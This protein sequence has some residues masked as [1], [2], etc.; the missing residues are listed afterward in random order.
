ML[1][2]D[3]LPGWFT[4][5]ALAWISVI[6]V[7]RWLL[8]RDSIMDKRFNEIALF[9]A[10]SSLLREPRVTEWISPVVPGGA[11]VINDVW[12]FTFILMCTSIMG[13]FFFQ[14]PNLDYRRA[15]N[16]YRLWIVVACVVGVL[17]VILS[18]SARAKGL[19]LQDD[20]SWRYGTYFALYGSVQ[21]VT[22]FYGVRFLRAVRGAIDSLRDRVVVA[23]VFLIAIGG[24]FNMSLLV[25]GTI[26][27]SAGVDDGFTRET[28]IRASGE[29]L[30]PF[31]A[32]GFV[33]LVPSAAR[34]VGDVL[35]IDSAS[36]EARRLRPVWRELLAATP[37]VRM[38]LTLLDRLGSRSPER[39]H[40]MRR[41]ISH[42]ASNVSR[43]I[44]GLDNV[45]DD[46]IDKVVPVES[47]EPLRVVT[48]LMVAARWLTARGGLA[49]AGEPTNPRGAAIDVDTLV[50]LWPQAREVLDQ[51]GY[52]LV[53]DSPR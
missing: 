39:L 19:L 24:A 14:N 12:H 42:A 29:L 22:C 20:P 9:A 48:E 40:R 45:V 28:E 49:V 18:S 33:A 36:S 6:T 27:A 41:E 46:R 16:Q 10:L 37:N 2:P 15:R 25:L 11:L 43:Y 31:V 35:R 53:G 51:P 44:T 5:A 47:Q 21:L 34:A 30:L 38:R 17:F 1:Q 13:L 23:V 32:L 7:I 8:C 3:R 50:D 4:F 52:R 26:M